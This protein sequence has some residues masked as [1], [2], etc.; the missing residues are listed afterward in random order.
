MGLTLIV[1]APHCLQ[2]SIALRKPIQAVI[3]FTSGTHKSTHGVYV[4]L[5]GVTAVL[6]DLGN[7]DLDR[8]VVFGLNDAVGG[9]AFSRDVT[10][11]QKI[12]RRSE[13]QL[14]DQ[15]F[16]QNRSRIGMQEDSIRVV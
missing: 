2:E 16:L 12:K 15:D 8:C 13:L 10:V 3:A 5:P 9:A 11:W 14:I 1:P 6:V 7:A 4:V